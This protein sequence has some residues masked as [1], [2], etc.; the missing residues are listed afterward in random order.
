MLHNSDKC[1]YRAVHTASFTVLIP[2]LQSIKRLSKYITTVQKEGK[3]HQ[4]K[5]KIKQTEVSKVIP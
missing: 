1:F 5:M 3:N 2:F 4:R